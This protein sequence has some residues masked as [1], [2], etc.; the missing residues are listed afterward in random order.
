MKLKLI[1]SVLLAGW[2]MPAM[3]SIV[4]EE[5]FFVD[6]TVRQ[7]G[8]SGAINGTTVGSTTDALAPTSYTWSAVTSGGT[9]VPRYSVLGAA[10]TG[11]GVVIFNSTGNSADMSVNFSDFSSSSSNLLT[12]TTVGSGFDTTATR[13]GFSSDASALFTAELGDALY[14]EI[15]GADVSLVKRVDG[16]STT[17][18]TLTGANGG[19]ADDTIVLQYN[20]VDGIFGGYF[21]NS[22]GTT[23]SFTSAAVGA[24]LTL[25]N[26]KY[27][28]AGEGAAANANFPRLAGTVLDATVVP[29]PATVGMLGLGA[30]AAWML[31]R[32]RSKN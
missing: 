29:E 30:L 2:M 20:T 5:Q 9:A 17:V 6:G 13:I 23:N 4:Y 7:E 21:V 24:G 15:A 16:V 11:N 26:V 28:F 32:V 8:T 25:N 10:T 3:A 1:A 31:R 27:E 12:L 19:S 14:I 22:D 18:Q